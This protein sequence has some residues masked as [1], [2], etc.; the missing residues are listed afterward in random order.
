MSD[1]PPGWEWVELSEVCTS[2]TDG[3][4]QPPPQ[5]P[6]GI[7]FLV[8]GNMRKRSLDFS[9]CRFVSDEYFK[10]L[11]SI[12]RPQKGD[13]LYS[14]VGATYGFAVSVMDDRPF[15]V[16][17]HIGIL[18]PS[19]QI[20]TLFLAHLLNSRQVYDQATNC[21]T[22]TA[23]P[24]VPLSG[25]RQIRIPLPPRPVQD[26]IA[27]AI[28]EQFSRLDAGVGALERARKNIKR[29]RGAILETAVTGMVGNGFP[30]IR[31]G[32]TF[33]EP[34]RNGHSAKAD[35]L[36]GTP[37]ITLTAVTLGDFGIHNVKM[38]AA[39]PRRVRDLWLQPGD[40]LIER[41]NTPEL[42]G[43]A[44]LYRG[45][46]NYAVYP[47]LIIRAR[48]DDRLMPEYAELLLKAPRTRRYFQQKAQGISG[49]MPKIDQQA[50]EDLMFTLPSIESQA[51][52]VQEA[53]RRLTLLASLQATLD[54]K[55]SPG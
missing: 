40:L 30:Q 27:G 31:F 34:L 55:H 18:R 20:S 41:S 19:P 26:R 9:N 32:D 52:T 2:I 51:A 53:E 46:P 47:D 39:D 22:G 5:A 16:Q 37:I 42:V 45:Q 12:R 8:I 49:T 28:E 36:G 35:P 1:L 4:H 23:Q 14:L 15:C 54:C 13:I 17:R 21:V 50:I 7:P 29:M 6:S 25:L 3:D 10:S 38:T 44:C 48:V 24:T 11:K 43:T 33:R